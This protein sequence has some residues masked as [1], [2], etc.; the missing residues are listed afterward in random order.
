M[1]ESDVHELITEASLF[2]ICGRENLRAT[3]TDD[4]TMAW[5]QARGR[6]YT[7]LRESSSWATEERFSKDNL[8]VPDIRTH[9]SIMYV[10]E[11]ARKRI[12]GNTELATSDP[13][14]PSALQRVRQST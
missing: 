5:M 7:Y 10:A 1:E 13:A 8:R 2:L 6:L 14:K 3:L 4:E 9:G 11:E 12:K